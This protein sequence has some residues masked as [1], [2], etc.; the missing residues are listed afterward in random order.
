[1]IQSPKARFLQND[2]ETKRLLDLTV[3]TPFLRACDFAMLHMLE[4]M[5]YSDDPVVSAACWHRV[6]GAK[7]FRKSLLELAEQPKPPTRTVQGNL[8]HRI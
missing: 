4:Q 1:M 7:M 8:N 5:D 6:E 3:E 2:G